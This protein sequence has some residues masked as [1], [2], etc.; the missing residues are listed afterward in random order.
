MPNTLLFAPSPEFS[1][2]SSGPSK[3]LPSSCTTTGKSFQHRKQISKNNKCISGHEN[4][5]F[6]NTRN[7]ARIDPRILDV[8]AF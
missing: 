1:D 8:E 3:S 4:M 7:Q 6:C 5:N 2:L